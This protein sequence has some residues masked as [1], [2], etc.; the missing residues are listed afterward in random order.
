MPDLKTTNSQLI[1][2][3]SENDEARMRVRVDSMLSK[4][5]T[6][7]AIY[8]EIIGDYAPLAR[9][10]VASYLY[11]TKD[12]SR[13]KSARYSRIALLIL[14]MSAVLV[15][16]FRLIMVT[17]NA[18]GRHIVVALVISTIPVLI[19]AGV[20]YGIYRYSPSSCFSLALFVIAMCQGVLKEGW[21]MLTN[22]TSPITMGIGGAL[23]SWFFLTILFAVLMKKQLHPNQRLYQFGPIKD[24]DGRHIF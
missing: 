10:S 18:E 14:T 4:G 22:Q 21:T 5:K 3:V 2:F 15:N 23:I 17:A 19:F 8:D 6:K 1:R 12:P 11:E 24:K 13:L 7:Q 16:L 9:D 20:T